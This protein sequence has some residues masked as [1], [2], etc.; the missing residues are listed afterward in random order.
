MEGIYSVS[1]IVPVHNSAVYLRKCVDSIR[2]QTLQNIEIILVENLSTDDSS[3][4][5]D[6]YAS[7]DSRIKVL[8]LNEAG[9]SIARNAGIKHASAPYIGF[10]DSD[11]HIAPTMYKDMFDVAVKNRAEVVY[12]N[13]CNEYEDGRVETIFQDSQSIY[14]RSSKEVLKDILMEKVSSGPWG[15]LFKR[16]LFSSFLFPEG[17]FFE[18]H[19]IVYKWIALCNKVLWIDRTYYYYLQ[20]QG[21]TCHTIDPIKRYHFFLAEYSRLVFLKESHFF[22]EKEM[23]E[24]TRLIIKNSLWHFKEFMLISGH[25]YDKIMLKDMLSKLKECLTIPKS[26]IRKR[27]YKRLKEIAYF[28]PIYYLIHFY[29]KKRFNLI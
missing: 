28:W 25:S 26:G 5:C 9:P 15:K 6:E 24:L 10:V 22:T 27:D 4:I 23:P 21:S 13:F 8:H 29:F 20:R 1:I 14:I 11:D 18:D 16:E 2:S 17:V 3:T 7:V 19:A 12:C